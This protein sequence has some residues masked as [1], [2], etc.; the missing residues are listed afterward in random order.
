M[1]SWGR[2]SRQP[3]ALARPRHQDE[4]VQA[5]RSLNMG[6]PGLAVGLGRSYGDSGLNSDNR[7]LAMDGMDRI[8]AFDPERRLLTAEAGASLSDLLKVL[9]PRGY[10]LPTTPGSRFVTL[11]GAVA[12]DVHGK[13][14]HQA[15]A[16][17]ASVESVALARTD[18]EV[19]IASRTQH[20]E[21]F[22][23]TLGGLGLTGVMLWVQFRVEPI[24]SAYLDQEIAPYGDLD[25]FFALANESVAGWDHTVAWID[26]LAR[27]RSLGRGVFSR[28]RFRGD[29]DF[30]VH[31]DRQK[32]QVPLE[33]P[34][35]LLNGVSIAS[36]NRAYYALQQSKAGLSRVHYEP[37][38]YPL[39]GIGAW[40]K[41]Y[42]ARGF[43]QYQSVVPVTD[44]RAATREMLEE[45]ARSGQGSFL[46][47]LKTFGPEKSPG[48][49]SFPME[50]VTLALDF[51][52]KGAKTLALFERLDAIVADAG[53]RLYPAKDGRMSALMFR[54]G[55]PR[56]AE[57][58]AHLDPGLSSDFWRR[59]NP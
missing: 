50:G 22:A 15:G 54:R 9:V 45:I 1:R 58:E 53:G 48:M 19:R 49:L 36:F 20:P 59:V 28:A 3:A 47:V 11:G 21:L 41:L 17:G 42:G 52:N 38:F 12:N 2:V 18:G 13:N 7:V 37:F 24:E 4:A 44:A 40:N 32:L 30:D 6:R 10:F 55:Y 27:G 57:F 34:G 8:L 29:G 16:F 43:Y 26:C 33:A 51:P 39:D 46:A 56:L 25:D 5:A 14:H 23:A 31:A 35:F